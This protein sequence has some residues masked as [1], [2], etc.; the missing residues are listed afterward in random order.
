FVIDAG[1][2]LGNPS[3]TLTTAQVAD[4]LGLLIA[5]FQRCHQA[6]VRAAVLTHALSAQFQLTEDALLASAEQH[7]QHRKRTLLQK[8]FRSTTATCFASAFDRVY[9]FRRSD[10][11]SDLE[12]FLRD[13]DSTM[14]RG[15]ALKLGNSSTVAKLTMDG[16]SVVIKRYNMKSTWHW[17][18][19]C[20]RP[21][22]A[23]MSWHN[24]HWL[25]LLG[26]HTPT[27]I[28]FLEMRCGPLR[29]RAYYVCEYIAGDALSEALSQR[30]P[31]N[32]ELA[33]LEKYFT[34]AAH[35]H[36]IHG[37]M[38]AT[39]FFLYQ[40]KLFV[41]DLDSLREESKR[42]WKTLFLRDL[43]RFQRN[44]GIETPWLNQLQSLVT[45]LLA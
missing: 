32:Q 10:A 24:A 35:E 22:R 16:R 13:P 36:L 8:C 5:Q 29:Q 28:A 20:W 30:N 33:E 39:N 3:H 15:R 7:W 18:R 17:L 34:T 31:S 6:T 25:D 42:R 12:V 9:A 21:S 26:L 14:A 2:I 38:K 19:R 40:E 44:W 23:W 41:L 11:G 27:P 37:D 45:R 4:N 1:A 43:Q